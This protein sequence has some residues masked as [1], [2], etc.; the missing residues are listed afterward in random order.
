[1]SVGQTQLFA[2]GRAL[3]KAATLRQRCGI[4][5]VVLLDEA[6]SSLDAATE[7]AIYRIIDE[8][9]T[10]HGH[11]VIIVAHRLGVLQDYAK[12]GRD[13]VVAMANGRLVA[14]DMV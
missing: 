2:L 12:P 11:T 13:T 8:E 3:I 6:T 14:V 1:M 10:A 7:S 5:P 4:R 9:L